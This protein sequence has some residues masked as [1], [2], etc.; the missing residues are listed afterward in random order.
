MLLPEHEFHVVDN[1]IT[2]DF[3][4]P[5]PANGTDKILTELLTHSAL[6]IIR[7]R[8]DRGQPIDDIPVARISAMR[9]GESVELAVL[10][11]EQPD[12]FLEIELPELLPVRAMAGY[13]P[14]AKFGER[15]ETDVLPLSE[16]QPDD[17]APIAD[18]IRLTAGLAAGLR[19]L[20]VD[21]ETMSVSEL[22]L[23][24][25]RLA[26]YDLTDRP[27]GTYLAAGHGTST[28]VSCVDHRPGDHPELDEGAVRTFLV[29]FATARA[30]RALLITDKYGPYL[31]YRKERANPD[32]LF[33]ARE[34]LQD[35]VDTIAIS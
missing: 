33:V 23:G 18:E 2:I 10:D 34:R 14:L 22:G 30:E 4:V 20:G 25:L 6:E 16:R 31:I 24:L 26:G 7:D 3:A 11:L 17:L 21:P 8:K 9:S 28:L 5:L 35:F 12:E 13:D 1:E 27:D 29:N 32:T 19:S 15:T